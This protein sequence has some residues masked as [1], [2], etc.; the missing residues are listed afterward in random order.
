[1]AWLN[2]H[3]LYYFWTV[4]RE[5]TVSAAGRA[6]RLAQPTVSGQLKELEDALGV[7][8]FHRRGRRL[9]L[10][11]VGGHVYRY[12]D[13]IFTLGRELQESLA[14]GF[15]GPRSRLVVGVADIIPKAIVQTLVEPALRLDERMRLACYE[16]R[17]ERL[18]AELALYQL[19]VVL[20]DEPVSAT[21]NIRGYNHLLGECAVTLFAKPAL[22]RTLRRRFPR[23]LE[24]VPFLLPIEQTSLR[25]GLTAWFDRQKVRPRVR[26]EVQDSA[27]IGALGHAGEGV[28]AAPSVIEDRVRAQQRV[29]VVARLD[30]VR[31]RFYAITVDRRITHPGVRAI[32]EAARSELFSGSS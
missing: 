10:T 7:Q 16:D 2:Y 18:L 26:A 9:V 15:E 3:H 28:F 31:A 22:A 8:L 21:S 13:E 27:L 12:A 11:D 20:T 23:S 30:D 25:R 6:L 29:A 5:G 19:D 1:M 14:G 17:H 32:T 24:D 4:V